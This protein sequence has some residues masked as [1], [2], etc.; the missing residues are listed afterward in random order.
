VDQ[1][2]HSD[3]ALVIVITLIPSFC[4]LAL[5]PKNQQEMEIIW[6]G[7]MIAGGLV[8]AFGYLRLGRFDPDCA[9]HQ[10]SGGNLSEEYQPWAPWVNNA[11]HLVGCRLAAGR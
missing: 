10:Q 4:P 8:I 7:V 1:N 6:N 2:L 9:R 11:H 3:C 5:F